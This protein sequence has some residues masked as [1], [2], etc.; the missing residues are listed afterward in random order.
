MIR[1]YCRVCSTLTSS[2]IDKIQKLEETASILGTILNSD[3]FID[4]PTKDKN[5]A[6]VV[7]HY[8]PQDK[9]L[10]SKGIDGEIAHSKNEPAVF[11]TLLTG[12]PSKNYKAI[13]Q[14]GQC[15]FQNVVSIKNDSNE[16]IGALIIEYFTENKSISILENFDKTAGNILDSIDNTRGNTIS[17]FVKDGIII[18]NDEKKVTY[19][20]NIAK[21]L[22]KKLG[23]DKNIVGEFFQNIALNKVEF[24]NIIKN[25]KIDVIEVSILDLVLSISYFTTLG[26][27]NKKNVIMIIRDVTQEKNK[28]QELI[29]KSV[30]IKEIHHRVKN[31]LQTIASLLRIQSRRCE[32]KE[33]KKILEETISRI[34]SIAITHE[35]LSENGLDNLN[36]RDI[37]NLI[38]KNY[39]TKTIDKNEKIEF[40]IEGDNFDVSSEKSTA[41]ALVINEVIQNIVDYAFPEEKNGKVRIQIRKKR[42]TSQII[43]SD[44]GVGM[45]ESKLSNKGLGLTIIEKIVKDQLNGSL[46]I[47]SKLGIGTKVQFEIKNEY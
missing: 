31:N 6:M 12:M 27:K 42:I 28:E 20:N 2:D 38:Y 14:E 30:A 9:S 46:K 44:N 25:K 13:N 32:S 8:R 41:I 35:V 1:N 22:Y 33:T 17:E 19:I 11:R 36:I 10:Y 16:I 47:V 3:V 43:I 4:C 34:L 21:K 5:K 15:V 45:C 7:Y 29:V 26:E 18:F 23:F 39:S 40:T 37:V 24:E